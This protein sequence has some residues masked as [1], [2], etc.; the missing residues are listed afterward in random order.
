LDVSKKFK[1]EDPP[2]KEESE[3][4]SKKKSKDKKKEKSPES[5]SENAD[6]KKSSKSSKKS[7]ER[8]EKD[9]KKRSR[10]RSSKRSSPSSSRRRRAPSLSP[11]PARERRRRRLEEER[12]EREERERERERDA[13]R[14]RER[15]RSRSRSRRSGV[16]HEEE[17]D[18]REQEKLEKQLREKEA[19]YQERLK[20]WETRE[21][22]KIR[23]ADKER[24]KERDKLKEQIKEAKR[25]KEFLEEY[26]DQ[27][28][29]PRFYVSNAL[30]RR[31]RDRE[32]EKEIDEK[33][34]L[35]EKEELDEILQRLKAENNPDPEGEVAKIVKEFE[36]NM[37]KPLKERERLLKE[38]RKKKGGTVVQDSSNPF[39]AASKKIE[40]NPLL[41][42]TKKLTHPAMNDMSAATGDVD[43]E[44]YTG[45]NGVPPSESND[46]PSVR[47]G[48]DNN[49]PEE[50]EETVE[51]H[52]LAAINGW[53]S[54]SGHLN[55]NPHMFEKKMTF[56]I[57]KKPSSSAQNSLDRM[58]MNGSAE[59]MR[60][61][62]L[63]SSN[64][65]SPTRGG[66]G[67]DW[68]GGSGGPNSPVNNSSSTGPHQNS[69]NPFS[70]N[71][72]LNNKHSS[73]QQSG[74]VGGKKKLQAAAV[75]GDDVDDEDDA[76][77]KKKLIPSDAQLPPVP[78]VAAK[79]AMS[80]EEKQQ[81]VKE[82][83]SRIPTDRAELFSYTVDWERVDKVL[84]EKRIKPWVT[85]KIKEYIGDD[86]PTLVDFICGKVEAKG[87]P[88]VL[89]NDVQ[90]VLDE[91]AKVFVV[92]LWRLLIYETEAKKQGLSDIK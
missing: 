42:P 64:Y 24:E 20:S 66:G 61:G 91:E 48:S 63:V 5:D 62:Q 9:H 79:P 87:D 47:S 23:E 13:E 27:R 85:K 19:A 30:N 60:E 43:G 39:K 72:T 92:K 49:D 46:A 53:N 16:D 37:N 14:R 41:S 57:G 65:D 12:R 56:E 52:K 21:K 8:D 2:E 83:I 74:K 67:G 1:D 10:E 25:L 71:T 18:K 40:S 73:S 81:K 31:L 44:S 59:V 50:D 84:M 75:F 26:D 7:K 28:D 86:E 36:E 68:T 22:K 58:Y 35:K 77:K 29:D 15:R 70:N 4:S 34:R 55:G 45:E 51:R 76:P 6:K 78:S 90:M 3:K 54:H 11:S 17:E 69:T 33:D 89:L 82:L 80:A 32:K 88:N 38:K